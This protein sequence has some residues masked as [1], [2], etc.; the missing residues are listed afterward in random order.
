MVITV[1]GN[2]AHC[3]CNGE[4]LEDRYEIPETG[5]IGLEGDRGQIEYRRIRLK[6]LD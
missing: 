5:G 2:I 1:N 3:T 4:I 6:V